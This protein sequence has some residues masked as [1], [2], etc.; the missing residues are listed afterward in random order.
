M[1]WQAGGWEPARTLAVALVLVLGA[2]LGGPSALAHAP[3]L[4]TTAMEV[5][6]LAAPSDEARV[7]DV[8]PGG[9]EVELTG[10]TEGAFLEVS[11]GGRLGW[12]GAEGFDGGIATAAVVLDAS[13]RAAPNADG[14][15]L[16]AVPA[17]R[18]VML[19]GAT[20]DGFVAAS[21]AGIGGWLPV[22]AVA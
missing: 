19:T 15:I 9:T 1:A 7:L 18:T 12:A 10:A 2:A 21:F 6:L 5:A 17:G 13:L 3:A 14:E 16:G 4:A 11:S 8:M 22:S 20:V